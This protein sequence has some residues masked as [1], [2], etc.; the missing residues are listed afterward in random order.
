MMFHTYH[1]YPRKEGGDHGE[2]VRE[3]RKGLLVYKTVNDG[4]HD[5]D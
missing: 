3:T 1:G 4:D 2:S 5:D